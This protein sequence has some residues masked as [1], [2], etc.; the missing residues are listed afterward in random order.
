MPIRLMKGTTKGTD[1]KSC[2]RLLGAREEV[3]HRAEARAGRRGAAGVGLLVLAAAVAVAIP[4]APLPS[5]ASPVALAA[6]RLSP[7]GLPPLLARLA[8]GRHGERD[9]PP[10]GVHPEHPYL[11]VLAELHRFARV[12]EAPARPHL[13]D[14]DEAFEPR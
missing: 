3:G 4:V 2:L 7:G 1:F 9:P 8:G 11:D 5:V 14:V 6:A 12:G 13:A 10:C